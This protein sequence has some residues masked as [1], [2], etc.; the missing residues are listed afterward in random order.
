MGGH[1]EQLER[2]GAECPLCRAARQRHRS[3]GRE[4]SGDIS[5]CIEL[6]PQTARVDTLRNKGEEEVGEGGGRV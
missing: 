6:F 2:V 1:R 5:N 3:R 4:Q